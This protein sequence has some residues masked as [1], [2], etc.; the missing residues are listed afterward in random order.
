MSPTY[1]DHFRQVTKMVTKKQPGAARS[2]EDS[3]IEFSFS[4]KPRSGE[5]CTCSYYTTFVMSHSVDWTTLI[6]QSTG[7]TITLPMKYAGKTVYARRF[8]GTFNINGPTR[9][10]IVLLASETSAKIIHSIGYLGPFKGSSNASI[11]QTFGAAASVTFTGYSQVI[12]S[13]TEG[14]CLRVSYNTTNTGAYY[15]TVVYWI[16][17]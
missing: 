9:S 6:P 14:I 2:L 10:Q 8:A 1:N 16:R 15:D 12:A 13:S 7:T 3:V 4:F 11:N 5:R 17:Q